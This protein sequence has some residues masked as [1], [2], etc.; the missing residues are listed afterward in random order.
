MPKVCRACDA[1]GHARGSEVTTRPAE[2]EC[3]CGTLHSYIER[4]PR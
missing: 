3:R 4:T 1:V 2:C